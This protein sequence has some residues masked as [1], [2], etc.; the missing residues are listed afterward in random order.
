MT[1]AEREALIENTAMAICYASIIPPIDYGGPEVYW[2]TVILKRKEAYRRWARYAIDAAE[3]AIRKDAI[4][5]AELSRLE[6]V[7]RLPE[8]F[9][10]WCSENSETLK[11]PIIVSLLYDINLLPEVVATFRSLKM[12]RYLVAVVEHFKQ[13]KSE[14]S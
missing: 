12:M 10:G 6:V 5:E 9:Y 7:E 1:D 2:R 14:P 13:T 11:K 3:S 4:E 8:Q